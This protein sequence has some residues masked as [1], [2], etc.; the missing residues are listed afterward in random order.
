[1][2]ANTALRCV[3]LDLAQRFPSV[4]AATHTLGAALPP[5]VAKGLAVSLDNSTTARAFAGVCR[6]LSVSPGSRRVHSEVT[7]LKGPSSPSAGKTI[8]RVRFL[9]DFLITM[10]RRL[11]QPDAPFLARVVL[12]HCFVWDSTS[13][14]SQVRR[15]SSRMGESKSSLTGMAT[16]RLH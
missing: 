4:G 12:S 5:V 10:V 1:M 13:Q 3:N 8:L 7:T 15:P 11:N 16:S 14:C 6:V 9:A 2:T